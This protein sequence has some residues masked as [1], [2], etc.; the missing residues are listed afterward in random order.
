MAGFR[1]GAYLMWI[2]LW[3]RRK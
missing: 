3:F 1:S 2:L